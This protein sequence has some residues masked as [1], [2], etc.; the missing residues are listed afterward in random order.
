MRAERLT[1]VLARLDECTVDFVALQDALAMSGLK[2]ADDDAG[3]AR[4]AYQL[5]VQEMRAGELD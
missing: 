4:S 1:H 3:E 2:L 5:A